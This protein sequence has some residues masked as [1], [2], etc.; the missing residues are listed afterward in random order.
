MEG[1]CYGISSLNSIGTIFFYTQAVGL[2]SINMSSPTVI[3]CLYRWNVT[4]PIL[5]LTM[6]AEVR[7]LIRY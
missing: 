3:A 4:I 6:D 2:E 5:T 1:F 7:Q